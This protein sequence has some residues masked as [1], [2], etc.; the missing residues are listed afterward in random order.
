MTK[1]D[2]AVSSRVDKQDHWCRLLLTPSCCLSSPSEVD[3]CCAAHLVFLCQCPYSPRSGYSHRSILISWDYEII[4]VLIRDIL[5][6]WGHSKGPD[7]WQIVQ[8]GVWETE[9]AKTPQIRN[10]KYEKAL[11][12]SGG[13]S[14]ECGWFCSIS[15]ALGIVTLAVMGWIDL[16]WLLHGD[17]VTVVALLWKTRKIQEV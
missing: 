17:E 8:C 6:L 10:M 2:F 15:V 9:Q 7:Q 11:R 4:N 16:M 5:G 14:P 3:R 1:N 12:V 13:C